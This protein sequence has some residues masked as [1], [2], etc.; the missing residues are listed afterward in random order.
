M[1]SINVHSIHKHR[2][3]SLY[4][5]CCIFLHARHG[6]QLVSN[7]FVVVDSSGQMSKLTSETRHSW[8]SREVNCL[9]AAETAANGVYISKN[10][11]KWAATSRRVSNAFVWV[12][13][14]VQALGSDE[15]WGETHK[16][17]RRPELREL[18]GSAVHIVAIS[19]LD[20]RRTV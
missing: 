10:S 17:R 4:T 5:R 13:V 20:T 14:G 8:A 19:T 3:I 1:N 18:L 2:D 16:R 9:L 7:E 6:H 11:I 12:D 15:N